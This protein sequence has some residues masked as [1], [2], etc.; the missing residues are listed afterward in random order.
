MATRDGELPLFHNRYPDTPGYNFRD[1]SQQA[2]KQIKPAA[3]RLRLLA[4]MRLRGSMG[5]TCDE[6]EQAMGLSHQTAS[7]RL[8]EMNLKGQVV[9]SGERRPT[10]SGR[11]AIVWCAREGWR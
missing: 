4:E 8:R 7:A 10:R 2:A 5:A 1:T 9:D 3:L 6:L 11:A